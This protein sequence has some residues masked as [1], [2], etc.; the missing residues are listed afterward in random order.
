MNTAPSQAGAGAEPTLFAT[1]EKE[2][3]LLN[4]RRE[5]RLHPTTPVIF[6]RT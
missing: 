1:D 3:A 2:E 6:G 4:F 5:G